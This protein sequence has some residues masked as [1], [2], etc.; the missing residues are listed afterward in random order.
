MG[1]V[2]PFAIFTF[3]CAISAFLQ[4]TWLN[5]EGLFGAFDTVINNLP[6][7]ILAAK[8]AEFIFTGGLEMIKYLRDY[9]TVQNQFPMENKIRNKAKVPSEWVN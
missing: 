8:M 1:T 9:L 7:S 4:E 2:V 6:N 5:G 3:K